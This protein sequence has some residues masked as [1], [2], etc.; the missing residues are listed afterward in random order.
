[1]RFCFVTDRGRFTVFDDVNF[2][3]PRVGEDFNLYRPGAALAIGSGTVK[4]V[5]YELHGFDVTQPDVTQ[6]TVVFDGWLS[7][8]HSRPPLSSHELAEAE[9]RRR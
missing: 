5:H 2:P 6:V 7:D 3:V 8:A 4:S 1:L 9:R